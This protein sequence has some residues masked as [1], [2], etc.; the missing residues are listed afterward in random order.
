MARRNSLAVADTLRWLL[1][2]AGITINGPNPWDIQVHDDRWYP[3]V[4]GNKSLG[5]GESYMDGWWD[6]QRLDEMIC[7]LLRGRLEEKVRGNLHH[8]IRFIPAMLFNL[9]SRSRARMIAERHYDLGND[10]FFSFLDP[11]NQYSCAYFEGTDDLNQAQQNKL[12]LIAEKLNI[13]PTDHILDIGCGWGGLAKYIA[14]RFGSSVTAVNISGEQLRYAR[15][16]CKGLPVHFQ[17]RDYRA[18]HGRFDKIVSVGMFEH[19][20]RKNYRTFMKTVHRCLKED[21]LFLLH[22]IGGNTSHAGC[23]PWINRYIFPNG[24]IPSTAQIAMAAEGLFVIED[25]H[26][27]GPHYEK[28]L[29]AWN[30]NFRKAWPRLKINYD[31]R[32]KRMWEYYLLSCAGAFRARDNQLWQIVMTSHG[33]GTAQPRCRFSDSHLKER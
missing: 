4:L 27:L 10:L 18:I 20:G 5:L 15:D 29:M 2:H 28:T 13:A 14:E 23:E 24:M 7:R 31:T 33:S 1:K 30:H 22:T 26:N 25:W 17:D 6:C 11:Y 12:A 16:F 9:Q 8:A 21:G 3:R 19:V 32:F